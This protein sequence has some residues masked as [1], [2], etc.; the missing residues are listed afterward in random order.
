MQLP[1]AISVFDHPRRITDGNAIRRNGF[2]HYRTRTDYRA[3]ANVRRIHDTYMH[4]KISVIAYCHLA[5]LPALIDNL[6]TGICKNMGVRRYGNI[7]SQQRICPDFL[8]TMPEQG[9]AGT[10]VGMIPNLDIPAFGIFRIK[11]YPVV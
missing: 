6:L 11:V 1:R 4:T 10:N 2:Y 5:H 3:V 8:P 7:L 9:R